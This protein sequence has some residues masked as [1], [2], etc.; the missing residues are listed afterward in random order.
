MPVMVTVGDLAEQMHIDKHRLYE[1]AKREEDP[2]PLRTLN[3]AQ[4]SSSML[5]EDWAEWFRRN[6]TLF[7]EVRR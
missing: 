7:K 3:G 4:R 6:S 5:C 1:L 2:L